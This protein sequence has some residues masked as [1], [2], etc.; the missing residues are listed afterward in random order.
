MR[1]VNVACFNLD[2]M[3]GYGRYGLHLIRALA[4]QGVEVFPMI[5]K[6]L[7]MESWLQQLKGIDFSRLTIQLMV[8]STMQS[9]PG[10][11]WGYTMVE[12]DN[13][14]DPAWIE[15]INMTCERLLV[16]CQHNAEVFK[17]LGVKCPIHVVPGGIDPYEFPVLCKPPSDRPYTFVCLGDRKRR[18]GLEVALTA[19]VQAFP[20]DEYPNVRL[21]VKS[22]PTSLGW[23]ND[24]HY[25]N[26]RRIT[27]WKTDVDRMSDVFAHADCVVYPSFGEG[28]GLWPREAA[29]SGLPVIA[30]RWS[31]LE[32]GIDQ[33]GIPINSYTLTESDPPYRGKWAYPDTDEVISHMRW[34]YEN[35]EAAHVKGQQA[36]AWVRQNQTWGHSAQSLI[37]LMERYVW[38]SAMTKSL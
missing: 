23:M 22:R 30:T 7:K 17:R 29:A 13:V 33:W 3:D 15:K 4:N 19:F 8:P 27:I 32:D 21:I 1:R 9:L 20:A 35:R 38:P 10:R 14:L 6:E 34:C 25:M 24:F 31:G 11:V 28:W 2:P 18:K 36:A 37:S 26:E 16:P 12:D 5:H